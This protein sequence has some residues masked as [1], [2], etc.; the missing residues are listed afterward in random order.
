MFKVFSIFLY[1][2][3]VRNIKSDA[4]KYEGR[5]RVITWAQRGAWRVFKVFTKS[6][7]TESPRLIQI[8][9]GFCGFPKIA[10]YFLRFSQNLT[11]SCRI[12][13]NL[14]ESLRIQQ[15]LTESWRIPQIPAEFLRFRQI[16]FLQTSVDFC[17]PA[18]SGDFF[19]SFAQQQELAHHPIVPHSFYACNLDPLAFVGKKSSKAKTGPQ[20][21]TTSHYIAHLYLYCV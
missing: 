14:T 2:H 3:I 1:L 5:S 7:Q 21:I 20:E 4:S 16:P 10:T 15:N 11:E 13:Q 12:W 18:L 8:G 19:P 17:D 6:H 9:L